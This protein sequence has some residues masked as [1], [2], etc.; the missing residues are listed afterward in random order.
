M[1]RKGRVVV[2]CSAIVYNTN[3]ILAGLMIAGPHTH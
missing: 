1:R 3:I 2:Q